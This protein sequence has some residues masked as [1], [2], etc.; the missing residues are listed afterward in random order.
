MARTEAAKNTN[1]GLCAGEAVSQ[2]AG[3]PKSSS[4][5]RDTVWNLS[6]SVIP[7][8]A[9]LVTIP[10]LL[11]RLGNEAF[12]ILALVWALIGSFGVFDLGTGRALTYEVSKRARLDDSNAVNQTIR[13][14]LALTVATG[15]VGTALVLFAVA[16]FAPTWFHVAPDLAASVRSAFEITA[17]AIIPTTV[18]SGVRGALEGFRRFGDANLNR[19]AIGTL[20]FLVPAA[21]VWLLRPDL[22]LIA[23]NLVI[24]RIAICAMGLIQL[25]QNIFVSAPLRLKQITPLL[26]F[27]VWVT[28]SGIISPLMVYGD[29]FLVS[30][31]L[32]A[33]AL[34]I[35]AIPQEALQRLSIVPL[36]LATALLPRLVV[37]RAVASTMQI[38]KANLWRVAAV[39]FVICGLAAAL[40][41]PILAAWISPDFADRSIVIVLILCFGLWVN[42]IGQISFTLL[43]ALG[44]PKVTALFHCL[45]LLLYAGLMLALCSAFGLVGAAIAW[46]ARV[47]ADSLLLHL[48]VK[49]YVAMRGDVGAR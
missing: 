30:Y 2:A 47:S 49:R 10:Y 34:P 7:L 11:D 24:A 18:T 23:A 33:D 21:T 20:M 38:Y 6:G 48:A 1:A 19:A 17:Y 27:G 44:R 46:T 40:A 37:T 39:M 29:R 22:T 45:E 5:R 13:A 25:R 35:Y 12:G 36:A 15:C 8:L 26:S 43:H 3:L 9:G 41:H 16:P 14:G 32:G 28:I 31:T 4:L 42:S